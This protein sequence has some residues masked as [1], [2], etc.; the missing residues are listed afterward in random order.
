MDSNYRGRCF[1][2]VLAAAGPEDLLKVG[3]SQDPL[4]R[5]ASFHLRWFE[6]F[7]LEHSL[8]VETET[9]SDAQ[10][11]ETTLHRNLAEHQCPMPLT[12]RMAAGGAT[13]WYRGS[14]ARAYRF[15]HDCEAQGFVV[16]R[17]AKDWLALRMEAQRDYLS[18][19][20][21]Y[22]YEQHCAGGL[23]LTQREIV[24]AQVD[25]QRAF[26]ADIDAIVPVA[27]RRALQLD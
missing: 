9:R 17:S 19:S 4:S 7:D 11:L 14:Y 23:N 13:E 3:I 15:V 20:L 8:F 21:H 6:V 5:W 26:G 25:G 24:Q 10:A 16:H 18:E 27:I 22:A 1:L 12:I 2:Y